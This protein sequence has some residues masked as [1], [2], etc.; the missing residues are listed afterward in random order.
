MFPTL[1]N[2]PLESTAVVGAHTDATRRSPVQRHGTTPLPQP[3]PS[4]VSIIDAVTT[5]GTRVGVASAFTATVLR[6]FRRAWSVRGAESDGMSG[7][8]AQEVLGRA[9]LAGVQRSQRS[10]WR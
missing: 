2:N 7:S 8:V 10:S 4:P 5:T 1:S 3:F 9:R 6:V